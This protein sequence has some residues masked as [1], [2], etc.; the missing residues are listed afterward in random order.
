MT[1]QQ[2]IAITR[3]AI[4]Q[5]T[6]TGSDFT[7]NQ[8]IGFSNE[9]TR[10]LST[11]IDWPRDFVE[12]QAELGIGAYPLPTDAI[13]LKTAY[14]GAKGTSG[15]LIPLTIVSEES[16]METFPSWQDEHSNAF[17]RPRYTFLLDRQTLGI[18][19]KPDAAESVGGKLLVIGYVY[20]PATMSADGDEPD[21]PVAFHDFIPVYNQYKCYKGKLNNPELGDNLLKEIIAK[22][23]LITPVVT[24]E[25]NRLQFQWGSY[26]DPNETFSG[27]DG[28]IVT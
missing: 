13:K 6:E 4:S 16:L 22:A 5:E 19:P 9:G 7:D 26:D 2:I 3:S 10:F 21:L 20:Y 17:G 28:L 25:I 1:L 11:L 18:Y 24:K 8:L 14:F 27:S 15:D 12:V 23:K